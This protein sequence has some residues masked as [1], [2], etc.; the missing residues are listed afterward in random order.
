MRTYPHRLLRN[1]DQL[2]IVPHNYATLKKCHCLVFQT[3][4]IK[5]LMKNK[6]QFSIV[7]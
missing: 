1:A 2:Y 6:I 7:T 3:Y 5:K 4:E